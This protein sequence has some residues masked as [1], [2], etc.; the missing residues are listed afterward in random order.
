MKIWLS[1]YQ[2][3]F[4]AGGSRRGYLLKLQTSE[5]ESGYADIFP[6]PEFGDPNF[7]KVPQQLQHPQGIPL[8]E[9]SLSMA[10]LDGRAREQ[11]APLAKGVSLP[12]HFL[13]RSL[14]E[15]SLEDALMAYQ[16]GF[17]TFKLKV[18]RDT[19][20]EIPFILNFCSKMPVDARLR[21]DCNG[22][23]TV[24]FFKEISDARE[25]VD[26]VEDPFSEA[27]LW[28]SSD[29]DVRWP[30]A[31]DQPTVETDEV[32]YDFRIIKPA[33]QKI[34]EDDHPLVFTSYLDH[35]VGIAHALVAAAGY[36]E[37]SVDYG[38]MS[39]NVYQ[40]TPFHGGLLC[41]GPNLQLSGEVGVGFG[42][43]L[44]KQPWVSVL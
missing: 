44:E 10:E 26:F 29:Q 15:A 27:S 11:K 31:Y 40:E 16:Q 30:W 14:G 25:R 9:R 17:R 20:L 41:Q 19:D 43:L 36:G 37:P 8:L 4:K 21:L 28:H 39:L 42:S 2:L 3:Q 6:W 32:S 24:L 1:D 5:F 22:R 38:L 12:N 18:M 13:I 23:G 34:P 33:K 35:P 7:E